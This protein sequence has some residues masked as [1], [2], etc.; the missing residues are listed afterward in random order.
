[1]FGSALG[2]HGGRHREGG[3]ERRQSRLQAGQEL[4]SRVAPCGLGLVRGAAG[5]RP[6]GLVRGGREAEREQDR[7]GALVRY[8]RQSLAAGLEGIL[9]AALPQRQLRAG[10]G[11]RAGELRV[12]LGTAGR[13]GPLLRLL[14]PAACSGKVAR[15]R[16]PAWPAAT[17]CGRP[18]GPV[19]RSRSRT[20][21]RCRSASSQRPSGNSNRAAAAPRSRATLGSRGGR[22]PRRHKGRRPGPPRAGR[23]QRCPGH[24]DAGR[25]E[26]LH[27]GLL[28]GDASAS[29]RRAS[30]PSRSPW[31]A[32]FTPT[33]PRAWPSSTGRRRCGHGQRLLRHPPAFRVP[34][35]QVQD[36][37]VPGQHPGSLGRWR[38][39]RDQPDRL[40]VGGQGGLVKAHPQV[41]AEPLMQQAGPE[42]IRR[43]V[44]ARPAPAGPAR[45]PAGARRASRPPRPPGR[46][47]SIRSS[48]ASSAGVAAPAPQL[49]GALVVAGRPRQRRG[50]VR[51]PGPASTL[52]GRAWAGSPAASQWA[53]SSAAATA[54]GPPASS[55][56]SVSAW[57]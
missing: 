16:C 28:L 29:R 52:A 10:D 5:G 22:W 23:H 26:P 4:R 19:G 38:L 25:R 20:A 57:A 32:S 53:A 2:R 51:R 9:V 27:V 17:G 44:H 11:E 13:C 14:E 35:L 33:R 24:H 15:G 8:S 43:Q 34:G 21:R 46:A 47:A 39:G 54:G 41:A 40:L 3:I 37:G 1:M 6:F 30:P 48:P 45:P 31:S 56:R 36:L 18:L 49:Q 55:G 50:R 42:R 12:E 7:V